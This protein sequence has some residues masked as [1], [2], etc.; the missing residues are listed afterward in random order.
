MAETLC[1]SFAFVISEVH[2]ALQKSRQLYERWND[3]LNDQSNVFK[4]ELEWTT[5]ELRFVI[6]DVVTA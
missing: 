6:Y 4:E 3:L 2:K 1:N 5:T